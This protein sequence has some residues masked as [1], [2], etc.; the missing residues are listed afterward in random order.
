M[1]CQ[2]VAALL[3]VLLP[4]KCLPDNRVTDVATLASALLIYYAGFKAPEGWRS[5]GRWRVDEGQRSS[6]SVW[7]AARLPPLW[8]ARGAREP[9]ENYR[10]CES[11]AEVAAVQ[12]LARWRRPASLAPAFG[13]RRVYRRF[14]AHAGPANHRKIIVRTKAALKPSQSRRYRVGEGQRASRQRLDCGA[15]TA[16][17][18][19]TRGPRTIGK[20]SPVRKRR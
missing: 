19:R 2:S 6:R 5:P 13:L 9:P 16:A 18:A 15:F 10:P 1:C 7:T 14:G 20:S 4:L 17:L 11:G 12:M 8:R 3:P